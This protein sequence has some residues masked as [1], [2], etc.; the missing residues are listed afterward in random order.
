MTRI[1]RLLLGQW[2]PSHILRIRTRDF[3]AQFRAVHRGDPM[4][5]PSQLGFLDDWEHRN[6]LSEC[7]R[8][9]HDPM[10]ATE[11]AAGMGAMMMDPSVD[12]W[13]RPMNDTDDT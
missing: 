8:L 1:A 11:E 3:T 4:P 12:T 5:P 6:Y 13:A 7:E 10:T 9:G 2:S